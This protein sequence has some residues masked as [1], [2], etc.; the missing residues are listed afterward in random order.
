MQAMFRKEWNQYFRSPVGYVFL[1]IFLTIGGFFFSSYT[2][3]GQ[4][5]DITPTFQSMI[6]ILMYL[7]PILTMRSFAEERK[8]KTDQLLYTAPIRDIDIV[9]GKF[10]AALAVFHI[11]M[12]ITLIYPFVI[13]VFGGLDFW[14][15]VGNYLALSLLIGVFMSIGIFISSITENQIVAAV[16]SYVALFFLWYSSN[17]ATSVSNPAV[18]WLLRSTSLFEKYYELTMGLMN[19]ASLVYYVSLIGLFLFLSVQVIQSKREG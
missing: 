2:L 10:L 8:L 17:L 6:V 18:L 16:L 13:A 4:V 14:V 3:F 15:T 12:A 9:M 11:G 19:P 5:G 7:V 1:A